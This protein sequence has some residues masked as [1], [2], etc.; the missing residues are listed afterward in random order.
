MLH[1]NYNLV[2]MFFLLS[3]FMLMHV[4]STSFQ[5]DL[6]AKA[7]IR[8]IA[9]RFA[10]IYPLH[11]M[12]M[13]IILILFICNPDYLP[14]FKQSVNAKP[15]ETYYT[16]GGFV[17]TLTLS[18][19]WLIPDFGVWNPV[20]WS[21]SAE[22]IACATFPF[23]ARALA[24][25]DS[26]KPCLVIAIASLV[27][28]F[29]ALEFLGDP[30]SIGRLGLLRAVGSFLAGAAAYR[31]VHLSEKPLLDPSIAAFFFY[32]SC[33]NFRLFSAYLISPSILFYGSCRFIKLSERLC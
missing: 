9:R 15:W 20:T 24:E 17:Q 5:Q 8:F 22:L 33:R 1:N 10:R 23:F 12:I 26:A 29:M 7:I 3:G 13:F 2:N 25:V 32:S 18:N 11:A 16:A 4:Y 6:S 27:V 30:G 28:T 21:L 19:R 14:W 31:F